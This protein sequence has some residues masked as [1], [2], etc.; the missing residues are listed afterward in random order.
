MADV[1]LPVVDV[2][3]V[4]LDQVQISLNGASFNSGTLVS[5][6]A[7]YTLFV[8]ATDLAGNRATAV[9]S[10]ESDSRPPTLS[11]TFPTE[12]AVIAATASHVRLA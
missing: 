12:G 8:A 1:D 7:R 2:T 10:F 6:D 5:G 11:F 3:D 4:H 9:L